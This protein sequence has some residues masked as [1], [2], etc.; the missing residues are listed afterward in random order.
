MPKIIEVS[1]ENRL[2][3]EDREVVFNCNKFL[4]EVSKE[5]LE[6]Q[7]I[8]LPTMDVNPWKCLE[9][10]QIDHEEFKSSCEYTDLYTGYR[11]YAAIPI[12]VFST[13]TGKYRIGVFKGSDRNISWD[14]EWNRHWQGKEIFECKEISKLFM[15]SGYIFACN[16]CDGNTKRFLAKVPL[17]NGDFLLCHAWSWIGK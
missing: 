10:L 2:N 12:A 17:D 3:P 1:P 16:M 11:N 13:D 6:G 7:F 14:V 8:Y 4:S 5:D 9:W 15:G